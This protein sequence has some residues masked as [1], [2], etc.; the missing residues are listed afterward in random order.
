MKSII[1]RLLL[2]VMLIGQLF[3]YGKSA[4]SW[5]ST[6]EGAIFGGRSDDQ[7]RTEVTFDTKWLTRQSNRIY[8]PELAQFCALLSSDVYF[9]EKDL[10]N[11][12][13]NRVVFDDLNAEDY[14]FTTF[15]SHIG[16]T[17][18]E[19]YESYLT[20][21][22]PIDSNDSVTLTMGHQ[23]VD[24]KY[25]VYA[26]VI[27]GCF[28]AQEWCSAFDP[29]CAGINYTELTGEHPEWTNGEHFKGIDVSASRALAYMEAFMAE[30]GDDLLPDRLLITGHSRGGG[31]ANLLGAYYEKDRSVTPYTYTFNSPGV[32]FA[33]DASCYR[34][35]FNVFD[36]N[37]F[38]TDLFPFAAGGFVRYGRDMSR[39]VSKSA[40][41]SNAVAK[42]KGRN[43]YT[44]ISAEAAEAYHALFAERFPD[45]DMLCD[46]A[47]I[48]RSF[49]TQIEAE[50][51]REAWL[52]LIGTQAG[53]GLDDLCTVSDIAEEG[54]SWN[55]T[56]EYCGAALLRSYAKIL[57]YGEAAYNGVVSLFAEDKIGCD[58]AAL[59]FENTADING[60]HLLINSYIVA[61]SQK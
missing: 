16:F 11:Q 39:S 5:S 58:I 34:T 57:A 48:T 33:K 60:G 54:G 4:A 19:H 13:Q 55:V 49:D 52:T 26:V 2:V 32:T 10:A 59:L 29:G 27:R 36:S 40:W 28:S 9:R 24:G 14:D 61:G 51:G 46:T 22:S 30:N 25:D 21:K 45:R 43:D 6:V 50:A 17:E 37:D 23:T 44:C 8:N 42:L 47:T 1:A 31:V 41:L 18:V 56:M 12:R 53:L 3:G 7:I 35:I 38:F 20:Q 15:L